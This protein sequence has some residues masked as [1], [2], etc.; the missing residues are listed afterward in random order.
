MSTISILR[1]EYVWIRRTLG[2]IALCA[3]VAAALE[4]FGMVVLIPMLDSL[5]TGE[6]VVDRSIGPFRVSGAT[7]KVGLVAAAAIATGAALQ[8]LGAWLRGRATAAW[9]HRLRMDLLDAHANASLE[10]QAE[11]ST[12]RMVA[13]ANGH[14]DE[15]ANGARHLGFALRGAGGVTAFVLGAIAIDPLGSLAILVVGGALAALVRP[16]VSN[17]RRAAEELAHVNLSVADSLAVQV[18]MAA[19]LRVHGV[20]DGSEVQ[21]RR[22]ARRHR[23]ARVRATLLLGATPVVFRTLGLLLLVAVVGIGAGVASAPALRIGVVALLLYRG[24][25]YAQALQSEWQQTVHA[26]PYLTGLRAALEKLH[27]SRRSP[28]TIEIESIGA[29]RCRDVDYSFSTDRTPIVRDVDLELHRG[30]VVAITGAS[31]AGKT[32]LAELLLGLRSAG[33]G[34][35]EIDGI[36][37]GD[38]APA[39]RATLIGRVGQDVRIWGGTI[40]DNVRLHRPAIDDAA[41]HSALRAVGLG[42]LIAET[43]DGL[44]LMIGGVHRQLSGGQRQRLGVARA[45]VNEPQFVVLDEPTSAL[46]A[47]NETLVTDAIET[48]RGKALVVVIAHRP[49]TIAVADRVLHVANGT[50]TEVATPDL[51]DRALISR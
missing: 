23:K 45:I 30:E 50:V 42:D 6:A 36:N 17:S 2:A 33:R 25:S 34:T 35:I 13:L 5:L 46:D 16:L 38:I 14:A 49:A 51:S 8:I 12:S 19:D 11:L 22:L 20:I 47:A 18:E 3:L 37:I 4:G 40:G 48:L 15:G 27:A 28:G 44:D 24:L 43:G 21:Y 31:G 29:L 10:A 41:I 32:T 9:Q 26:V 39:S 1:H 7:S